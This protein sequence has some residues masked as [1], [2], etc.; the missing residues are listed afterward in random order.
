MAKASMAYDL[1]DAPREITEKPASEAPGAGQDAQASAAK[2]SSRRQAEYRTRSSLDLAP[3]RY[4][5]SR[6]Y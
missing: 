5:E 4:P 1:K 3:R 6:K 2:D